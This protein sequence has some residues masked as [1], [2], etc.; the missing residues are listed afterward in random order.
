MTEF[1]T[2][3]NDMNSMLYPSI[4]NDEKLNIIN[5]DL[6]IKNGVGE[7]QS[8][9]VNFL[10]FDDNIMGVNDIEWNDYGYDEDY[11][12][13]DREEH[14]NYQKDEALQCFTWYRLN[15]YYKDVFDFNNHKIP[16]YSFKNETWILN[17]NNFLNK[18]L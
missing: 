7:S 6:M 3:K 8:L 15:N 11:L 4:N 12:L 1:E 14:K 2:M 5:L 10:L 16:I 17:V 18:H 13:E 9:L